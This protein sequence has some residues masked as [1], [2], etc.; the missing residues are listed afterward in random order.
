MN[1]IL[2]ATGHVGSEV[3]N[4]LLSAGKNVRVISRSMDRLKGFMA[5]GAIPFTGDIA[6]PVFLAKAFEGAD[7]VFTIIPPNGRADD[8]RKFQNTMSKS[9]DKALRKAGV[10][11]VVNL[12]SVGAHLK[13][14]TGPVLG[15]HDHEERLNKNAKLRIVHLRPGYFLENM[16]ANIDLI[17]FRGVNGSALKADTPLPFIASQDIAKTAAGYLMEG[18]FVGRSVRY[19]LGQRDLTMNELTRIL[20]KAIGL[21]DLRYQQFT[22]EDAERAMT[23]MGLSP[24]VAKSYVE[25]SRAFNEGILTRTLVRT[26][27]ST[28]ET[29][30]ET[31]VME[32]KRLYC[33]DNP[34][35]QASGF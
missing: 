10:T 17:K 20:G 9:I 18:K 27:E 16:L 12:S 21:P 3:A 13:G 28:T 23:T 33:V 29:S 19:L 5:K 25:L 22:Y 24:A 26:P 2:G 8:V 32:F 4:I 35:C 14:K 1:V 7:A 34:A 31:W 6:D 15:L 30:A 11:R